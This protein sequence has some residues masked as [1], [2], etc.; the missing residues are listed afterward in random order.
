MADQNVTDKFET[1][2][3][4]LKYELTFLFGK[5]VNF[6]MYPV[7]YLFWQIKQIWLTSLYQTDYMHSMTFLLKCM[8]QVIC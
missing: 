5:P 6:K 7:C 4:F 1:L 2:V 8:K 3:H